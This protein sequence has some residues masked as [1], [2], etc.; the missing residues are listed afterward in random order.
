MDEFGP[1]LPLALVIAVGVALLALLLGAGINA[2]AVVLV[3]AVAA[4]L[5]AGLH[6]PER[7][8][9]ESPDTARQHAAAATQ[10]AI[11]AVD[12][13]ILVIA[14]GHV[15]A[16]N[17]AA[18]A[19]LGQHV[20]GGDVRL[21]I[22]H[23][24]AAERLFGTRD[25]REPVGLVGLGARDQSWE[26]RV[27]PL[28]HDRRLVHLV[29]RTGNRATERMRV[30]FVA[31]ASHELRTPLAS[32]LG[33][34]ETLRDEAG[35]DPG[36]RE[37]FLKVMNDEA[38][39]M[40]RLIDDLISLSRIEA[41]K[42][43]PPD[44]A[45]DLSTMVPA[46]RDELAATNPTRGGDVA[47][48]IDH[49]VTVIGDRAQLSQLLHN[50]MGNAMKYGRAGTPVEVRLTSRDT[51][52]E[53]VVRDHGEGVA[54]EHL[55]RLTERFYRVDSGRS[56]ALGGTGLGLAIVKHIVE[57]HRGRL[58]IGSVVGDGTT[59]SVLLPLHGVMKP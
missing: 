12:E 55:P 47:L 9:T 16:A 50:V 27:R 11:D 42:Y 25:D 7:G 14:A 36:V 48:T 54:I 30:D 18:L 51:M 26:M 38:R 31:N 20:V 13:P 3:G 33:F 43:R 23:P 17:P 58:D 40:Q 32:L 15:E 57:R 6:A 21:A 22:R 4:V 35:E 19:L 28:T 59:V 56:R 34:I 46:V 10:S 39:R 2:S 1:R 24:A 53:L 37:R 8:P 45:V 52:A 49:D 5:V 41:E 44:Q 29:D